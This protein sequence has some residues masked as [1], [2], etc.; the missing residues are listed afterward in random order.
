[1]KRI[2]IKCGGSVID[3]LTSE[4]FQSLHH[5]KKKGYELIFVHGGGP[6]INKMLELYNVKP[7]YHNGLRKTTKETLEVVEMVLSGQTNRK[8]VQLLIE[9]GFN[10]MGL[11]GSDGSCLQAEFVNQEELGFVGEIINVNKQP[12]KMLLDNEYVP[13]MTPIGVTKEGIK[14]NI[15]ADYAAAAVASVLQVEHCLFITDVEGILINGEVAPLLDK[16]EVIG[17]IEN[18]EITGGMIPK[19]NS[20]LAAIEKGL[21]SVMIVSGKKSFFDGENWKGTKISGKEGIL[22]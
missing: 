15:N 4:F 8:L 6:D 13:V 5:L 1:M 12:I 22:K 18:G 11:N 17:Y 16:D 21:S 10:T 20:A 7:K 2:L 9:N 3:E 19:V 14:L